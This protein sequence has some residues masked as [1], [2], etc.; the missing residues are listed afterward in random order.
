[1]SARIFGSFTILPCGVADRSSLIVASGGRRSDSLVETEVGAVCASDV[2]CDIRFCRLSRL[3][4]LPP[5]DVEGVRVAVLVFAALVYEQPLV[6]F[7]S[8]Q[9]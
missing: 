1:L 7:L 9:F 6:C 8:E 5:V 2:V 4:R 3:E